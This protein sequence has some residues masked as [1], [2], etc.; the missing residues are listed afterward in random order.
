MHGAT[1]SRQP[2]VSAICWHADHANSGIALTDQAYRLA[3]FRTA[4]IASPT[5]SVPSSDSTAIL[6]GPW[7]GLACHVQYEATV[8]ILV[9]V[10][11]NAMK[12]SMYCNG[13]N[14]SAFPRYWRSDLR[15]TRCATGKTMIQRTRN[16]NS[17]EQQCRSG[18]MSTNGPPV[19]PY[20][21]LLLAL[22]SC[23]HT[24]PGGRMTA[25]GVAAPVGEHLDTM[26]KMPKDW[27]IT[28]PI[29]PSN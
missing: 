27:Y 8:P 14:L 17:P 22:G 19:Q 3:M 11:T 29:S 2:I 10:V 9:S 23:Y 28:W 1:R 6:T 25:N 16:T 24:G 12:R 20:S 26:C 18:P 13:P 7:P 21:I 5:S 15:H 4:W